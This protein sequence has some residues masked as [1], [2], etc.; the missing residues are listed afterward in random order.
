[1]SYKAQLVQKKTGTL[2][3]WPCVELSMVIINVSILLAFNSTN[4]L[5]M[6]QERREH[7]T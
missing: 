1:M 5:Y 7:S 6:K 4:Q 3:L 2:T